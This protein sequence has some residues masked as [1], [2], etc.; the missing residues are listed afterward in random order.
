MPE[1]D[2]TTAKLPL[3]RGGDVWMSAQATQTSMKTCDARVR[4]QHRITSGR[5]KL[6]VEFSTLLGDVVERYIAR[7]RR[8][9]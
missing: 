5:Y 3:T 9:R 1:A 7:V 2:A 6:R 4:S 8:V